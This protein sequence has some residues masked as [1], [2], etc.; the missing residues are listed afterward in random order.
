M[1][2]QFCM[3]CSGCN[4]GR[5]HYSC[6]RCE[7]FSLWVEPT[8]SCRYFTSPIIPELIKNLE[9]EGSEIYDKILHND[10]VSNE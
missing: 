7:R 3:N 5:K 10:S 4:T 6:V 8:F 9:D 1:D 2:K